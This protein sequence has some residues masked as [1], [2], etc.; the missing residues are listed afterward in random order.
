MMEGSHGVVLA[1]DSHQRRNPDR[2][3]DP[4]VGVEER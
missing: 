4:S 3:G 2:G 1:K